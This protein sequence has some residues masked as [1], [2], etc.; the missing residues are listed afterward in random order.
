MTHMSA[1][2]CSQCTYSEVL[3]NVLLVQHIDVAAG[4]TES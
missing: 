2:A 3:L 1:L 4:K